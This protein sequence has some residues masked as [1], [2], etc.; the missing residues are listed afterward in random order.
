MS[1]DTPFKPGVYHYP[2]MFRSIQVVYDPQG[3]RWFY[4]TDPFGQLWAY[5]DG[6]EGW[7]RCDFLPE[8]KP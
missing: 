3:V 5:V 8:W 2:A 1:E 4:G 7:R 6:V